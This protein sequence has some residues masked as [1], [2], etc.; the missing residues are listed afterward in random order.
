MSEKR[1]KVTKIKSQIY[2]EI[3][4]SYE[5][6]WLKLEFFQFYQ[7]QKHRKTQIFMWLTRRNR[8]SN[9]CLNQINYVNNDLHQQNEMFEAKA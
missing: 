7:H 6:I 1:Q 8:N 9:N 5:D 4:T 2:Q 3:I